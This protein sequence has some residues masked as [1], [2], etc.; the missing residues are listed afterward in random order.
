[1]A[2]V[3]LN[4]LVTGFAMPEGEG[5]CLEEKRNV[6]HKIPLCPLPFKTNSNS[7]APRAEGLPTLITVHFQRA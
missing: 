3:S 1:M 2:V 6:H 4:I 5:K 7:G